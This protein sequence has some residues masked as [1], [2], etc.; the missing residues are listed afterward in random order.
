MLTESST[1]PSRPVLT[2]LCRHLACPLPLC[3]VPLGYVTVQLASLAQ[4]GD[5]QIC[6]FCNLLASPQRAQQERRLL[7]QG[8]MGFSYHLKSS[9]IHKILITYK[10]AK[11]INGLL[12]ILSDLQVYL[13]CQQIDWSQE[14]CACLPRP[15][16]GQV[17]ARAFREGGAFRLT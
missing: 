17:A 7:T 2:G 11:S 1:R 10:L 13:L 9:V 3:S 12:S 6:Q 5:T 14:S 16:Y 15:R 4:G 8:L